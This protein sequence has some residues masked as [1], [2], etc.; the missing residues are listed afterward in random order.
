MFT[1]AE[2]EGE[3]TSSFPRN[4]L[5]AERPVKSS[6]AITPT[7]QASM[8]HS[9]TMDSLPSA[10]AM[11]T[12]GAAYPR[13]KERGALA[14]WGAAHPKSMTVQRFVRGSHM[15]LPGFRSRCTHPRACRSHTRSAML[16][17]ICTKREAL[18]TV[19]S[20]GWGWPSRELQGH[21]GMLPR[22]RACR[23]A[24]S[25]SHAFL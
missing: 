24:G 6:N 8:L 2:A 19:L 10:S 25:W 18:K 11:A 3:R 15:M 7:D 14:P 5:N 12:S 22:S 17:I 9:D 20:V 23:H 16:A 4:I 21:L 13:V 1:E